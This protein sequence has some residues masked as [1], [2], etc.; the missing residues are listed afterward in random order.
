MT[1]K[2][3]GAVRRLK[4]IAD[5][6]PPK[7]NVMRD[8]IRKELGLGTSGPLHLG[9]K[10]KSVKTNDPVR[11]SY[12]GA[13]IDFRSTAAGIKEI[14]PVLKRE[15][16]RIGRQNGYAFTAQLK[17]P[18]AYLG[19]YAILCSIYKESISVMIWKPSKS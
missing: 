8:I 9:G 6:Q 7:P 15:L 12:G 13:S 16:S 18:V 19:K 1:I 11:V 3:L 14:A 2:E 4:E 5:T 10:F 17:T